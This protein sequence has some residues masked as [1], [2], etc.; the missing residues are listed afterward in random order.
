MG[1]MVFIGDGYSVCHF[2]PQMSV[3]SL[4][5]LAYK[6]LINRRRHICLSEVVPSYARGFH[7]KLQTGL[8]RGGDCPYWVHKA[9]DRQSY[10]SART[11][12]DRPDATSPQKAPRHKRHQYDGYFNRQSLNIADDLRPDGITRPP[13]IAM[14]WL[15]FCFLMVLSFCSKS[16]RTS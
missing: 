16:S 11:N 8:D 7:H 9:P 12:L 3:S 5:P 15:I 1:D 4:M 6:N 10:W 13:P 14:S 2:L